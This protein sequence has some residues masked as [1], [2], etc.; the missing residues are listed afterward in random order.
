MKELFKKRITVS[1][2]IRTLTDKIV[3]VTGKQ[4]SEYY[5]ILNHK[6]NKVVFNTSHTDIRN[7]ATDEQFTLLNKLI[8]TMIIYIDEG[9]DA[10]PQSIL[11]RVLKVKLL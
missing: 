5:A 10:T 8:D 9:I 11:D 6:I 3:L 1:D 2:K 7:D 4:E